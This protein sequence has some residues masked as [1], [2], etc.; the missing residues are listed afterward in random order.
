MA[1][2]LPLFK[3]SFATTTDGQINPVGVTMAMAKGSRQRRVM[4]EQKWQAVG[5]HWSGARWEVTA[6]KMFERDSILVPSEE[7]IVFTSEDVLTTSGNHAQPT[8]KIRVDG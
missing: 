4:V 5:F 3:L 7:Q 8:A 1:R 6:T 2:L